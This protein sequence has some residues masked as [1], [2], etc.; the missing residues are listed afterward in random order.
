MHP[1]P[2]PEPVQ[3]GSVVLLLSLEAIGTR[4]LDFFVSS[5]HR[6]IVVTAWIG[7]MLAWLS[8]YLLPRSSLQ[9]WT[10]DMNVRV[11]H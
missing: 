6:D 2:E 7:L 4:T 9:T 3:A 5:S 11:T 10:V 1:E 8:F